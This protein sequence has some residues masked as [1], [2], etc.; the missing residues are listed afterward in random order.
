[1][2]EIVPGA[3]PAEGV[4]PLAVPFIGDDERAAVDDALRSG[5][6]AYGPYVDEMEA[7]IAERLG[8]RN[9][10]GVTS[11]TAALHVALLLAGVQPGD[12]VIVSTLT[13]ISPAFAIAYAG[14]HPVLMDA[15]SETWQLDVAK[16]AAFLEEECEPSEDG[17]RNRA[18]GRRIGALLPVAILGH[19]VDMDPITELAR[20]HGLPVVE[21]AAEGLGALYRSRPVGSLGDLSCLSFNGNKI[22]TCGGGGMIVTDDDELA[23]R[24]RYLISQAK[25]DPLEY[26]HGE[27]GFN[28]RL[29][30]IHAALGAVQL[31]R[32]DE[33]VAAKRRIAA[34]YAEA[35]TGIRGIA[36][37]PEADWAR[38]TF[39]L[40]T[41]QVDE[42]EF[43]M[44]SRE[45]MRRLLDNG[46]QVRP[47]WQPL[48]RSAA[49]TGAQAYRCECADVLHARGLSLPC[50]VALE[51]TELQRV[52]AEI[53]RWAA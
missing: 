40:Y 6:I 3:P 53:R 41:I 8:V 14:A 32:L 27:I 29:S 25:D 39:W 48:H 18:S 9:A 2:R 28:Y 31:S 22:I 21:D 33:F 30:N 10:V 50:S 36:T 7:R 43:G 11:G 15:E 46:V 17:L 12:E 1:L 19:P 52:A 5:W 42:Q 47:L 44:G 34:A 4:I 38:S 24:A 49:L 20:R 13:F 16:L 23:A 26:E 35:F 45:L 51:P 37:P